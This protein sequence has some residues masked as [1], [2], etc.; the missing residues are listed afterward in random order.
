MSEQQ[1]PS[2]RRETIFPDE[3][4]VKRDEIERRQERI[5]ELEK[6]EKYNYD[7]LLTLLRDDGK[8]IITDEQIDAAWGWRGEFVARYCPS[9]FDDVMKELGIHRCEGCKGEGQIFPTRAQHM[10]CNG[11]GWV[12]HE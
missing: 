7:S 5:E 4:I 9:L 1:P 10:D 12:K 11:H 8:R 3:M 2:G 6:L